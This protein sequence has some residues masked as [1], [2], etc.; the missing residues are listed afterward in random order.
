MRKLMILALCLTLD[1]TC[2]AQHRGGF[3]GGGGR[4]FS[5]GRG[6]GFGRGFGGGYSLRGFGR[7]RGFGL[8]FGYSPWYFGPGYGWYGY[9]CE[10]YY[11]Y[12]YAYPDTYYDS[13]PPAVGYS[14]P[15]GPQPV[16]EA[17]VGDGQW[18]HFGERQ[19]VARSGSGAESSGMR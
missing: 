11:P 19:Q 7:A 1:A 4:G 6:G 5:S 3:H 8:G 9:P 14:R 13:A 12:P 17:Y 16:V 2:F 18:H 10:P 15:A